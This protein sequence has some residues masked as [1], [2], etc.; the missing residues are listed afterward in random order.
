MTASCVCLCAR[1]RAGTSAQTRAA[2]H[3]C[4]I[5]LR[6]ISLS[7][8]LAISLSLS[9][10]LTLSLSLSP[11]SPLLSSPSLGAC[12]VAADEQNPARGPFHGF[13]RS[14]GGRRE[15]APWREEGGGGSNREDTGGGRGERRGVGRG[16]TGKENGGVGAPSP[17]PTLAGS[18][19]R[20]RPAGTRASLSPASQPGPLSRPAR[21]R[22]PARTAGWWKAPMRFLP[23]AWFTPVL[24]PMAASTIARSV[25]GIWQPVAVSRPV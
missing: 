8:S 16:G 15:V 1:A 13:I 24:P 2:A 12:K 6:P 23:R 20:R 21:R 14:H 5:R 10:S 3:E 7:R 4:G 9:L 17:P 22:L 18:V 19:S 11:L 25:V